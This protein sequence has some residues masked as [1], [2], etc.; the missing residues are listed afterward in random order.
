MKRLKIHNGHIYVTAIPQR[1]KVSVR[2]YDNGY[3]MLCNGR[4]HWQP[5]AKAN[6]FI[7]AW[8][9]LTGVILVRLLSP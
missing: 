9:S 7:L 1:T 8:Q 3:V 6:G 2:V 4:G 5:L